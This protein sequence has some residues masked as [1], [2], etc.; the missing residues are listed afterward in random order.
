M[1]HTAG[2]LFKCIQREESVKRRAIPAGDA[3]WP[4]RVESRCSV[5][6]EMT[7]FLPLMRVYMY[8][9]L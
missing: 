1:S 7:R 8:I 5:A 2:F 4:F 6:G 3:V 9:F